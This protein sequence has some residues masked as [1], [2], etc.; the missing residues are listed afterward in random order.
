MLQLLRNNRDIR[1]LFMAQ[2]ISFMGDWFAYVALA[3]LVNDATGSKILVSLVY[4]AFSLPSFLLSPIGGPVADRFDRRKVL[5]AISAGQALAAL[6][7]LLGTSSRVWPVFVFQGTISGLAAFIRPASEASVPNLAR[8]PEELRQANALLGSTW[9]VMLAL[10]AAIGGVFSQIFGRS[11]CFIADALSF[12]L[13]G[14]L[15]A[16]IRTPMQQHSTVASPSRPPMRPLA[17]M[18][19][20]GRFAKRDRVVMALI[21]SKAT[22]AI[23]SGVVSQLA[24]LASDVFHSGDSGRGLLIGVRGVGVGLGPIIAMRFARNDMSKILL[25]CG[26]AGLSFSVLYVGAAWAPTLWLAALLIALAH[27]GG[28]AQ[29]TI[30]SYGLQLRTPDEIR[31]RVMAGDFAIVTLVLS[32][33]SLLSGV[34]AEAFGVREAI[35]ICAG[36]AAV[37]G[38]VYL[39]VTASVRRTLAAQAPAPA[40]A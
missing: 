3:G 24:V 17:D 23:G 4:V 28:G 18:A 38:V 16:M 10:G 37:A 35:T 13:A 11:A 30:S 7:L 6:G 39:V 20:A 32:V 29:W 31:G 14:A 8:N 5:M 1:L 25:I 9:G 40:Q 27:L 19:E 22:F 26:A 15:F 12:V 36:A 34:L 2:V 21:A 33:T